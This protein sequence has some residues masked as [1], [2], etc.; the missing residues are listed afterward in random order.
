MDAYM[1]WYMLASKQVSQLGFTGGRFNQ[2]VFAFGVSS[3]NEELKC[4]ETR[5]RSFL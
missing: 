5:E 1:N 4:V 3:I 2:A